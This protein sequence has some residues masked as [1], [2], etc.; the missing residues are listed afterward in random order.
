MGGG[1]RECEG[2]TV[3]EERVGKGDKG[4]REWE[5]ETERGDRGGEGVEGEDRGGRGRGKG[6]GE[7]TVNISSRF[8][9]NKVHCIF[10]LPK[11]TQLQLSKKK[12]MHTHT[13]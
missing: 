8:S 4:G 10:T 9:P 1:K 13:P 12:H 11:D 7:T 3:G 2:E 5:G 6:E